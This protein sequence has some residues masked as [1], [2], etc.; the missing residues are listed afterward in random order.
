MEGRPCV[1]TEGTTPYLAVP[2]DHQFGGWFAFSKRPLR[3]SSAGLQ[4]EIVPFDLVTLRLGGP[5]HVN[6]EHR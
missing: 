2:N 3:M 4:T 6:F 1:S 5:W